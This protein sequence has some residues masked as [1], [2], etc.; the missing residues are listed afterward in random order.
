MLR[1]IVICIIIKAALEKT[2][3][4]VKMIGQINEN[5][6]LHRY[7]IVY[8]TGVKRKITSNN[9]KTD[10]IY[11]QQNRTIFAIKLQKSVGQ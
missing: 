8:C 5:M 10:Y 7:N 4:M 2:L 3:F 11:Y 6:L 1:R 9:S